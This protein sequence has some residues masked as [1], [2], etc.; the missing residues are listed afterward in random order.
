MHIAFY[1]GSGLLGLAVR[2]DTRRPGQA[3]ADVPAHCAVIFSDGTLCEMIFTGWHSRIAEPSDYAW[4]VEVTG[5]DE[6]LARTAAT[7]FTQ[8]EYGLW[9]DILIGLC[10]YVPNRWL[11]CTRGMVKHICSAF[12]KTVLEASGWHCP[13]WL[14]AQYAPESP[15]DLW[16]ALRGRPAVKVAP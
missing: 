7:H 13:H 8:A 15:N 16:F 5:I 11:S 2:I 1:H 3:Y 9:V 6:A 10:R 4:S 14:A 12:V